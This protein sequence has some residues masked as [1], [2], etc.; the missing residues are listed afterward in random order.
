MIGRIT[1]NDKDVIDSTCHE[2]YQTHKMVKNQA[3]HKKCLMKH[4]NMT[5][6]TTITIINYKM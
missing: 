6:M 1:N 3:N 5:T 4:T 2:R